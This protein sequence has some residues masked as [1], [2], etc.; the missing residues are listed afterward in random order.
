LV[1]NS[2]YLVNRS[3]LPEDFDVTSEVLDDFKVN[4]AGRAI[5][6]GHGRVDRGSTMDQIAA[7]RR[8]CDP[9]A[10]RRLKAM[11]AQ[12]DPEVQTALRAVE[13]K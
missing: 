9:S 3:P 8:D 5:Q 1:A 10:R 12:R 7:E 2:Q 11:H 4:L 6:T 13:G